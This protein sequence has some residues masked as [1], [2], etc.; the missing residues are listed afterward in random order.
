MA[1]AGAP[2]LAITGGVYSPNAAQRMLIVNGQV[3]N[4]GA[5]PVPGVLLEQIR[6][7][8]AVLSWRGQR[9]LVGY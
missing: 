7:N 2:K 4:E 9:Y 3:F 1:P 5:E 8:Q 6:P